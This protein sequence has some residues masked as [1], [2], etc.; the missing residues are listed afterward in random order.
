VAFACAGILAL[1]ATIVTGSAA[2]AAP[3]SH[4]EIFAR[5]ERNPM[6]FFLAKG[7]ADE[8]GP[9]CSEWIAAQG[10]FDH[11]SE[12]RLHSF[13]ASLN[14][15]RPPL[16]FNS[17]GGILGRGM[18]IGRILRERRMTVG[19][20]VSVIDECRGKSAASCRRIM[21]SGRELKAQLRAAGA[22]CSS[23][24][25]DALIGAPVRRIPPGVRLG[26]HTSYRLSTAEAPPVE[27]ER[28]F[29][30]RYALEMGVDP[31]LVDLAETIPHHRLHALSR[32]EI[33]QFGIETRGPYETSWTSLVDQ[34][35]R[36]LL[37]KSI[38]HPLSDDG[39]E[40]QTA[41]ATFSCSS[42]RIWF[43]YQRNLLLRRAETEALFRA[44][45]GES[46]LLL[47]RGGGLDLHRAWAS[48]RF[49]QTAV[50]EPSIVVV[51]VSPSGG[52]ERK[53]K[54]STEG[55]SKA[56]DR[57]QKECGSGNSRADGGR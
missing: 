44:E 37:L 41:S 42:G 7:R 33:V 43:S 45:A 14:G 15:R 24:C 8:C 1:A 35:K 11:G 28:I 9:G 56:L 22:E 40:Y 48:A 49:L 18:A 17:K 57:L 13:L 23:A 25:L 38:T 12:Q 34:A 39:K 51:E 26:I 20:G 52:S 30:K 5:I 47:Q 55:L 10:L 36:P 31:R 21:Q 32:S 2:T 53:V 4:Q 46:V 27:V 6:V 50:V 19:V 16:Y 54:L 29:R 3:A